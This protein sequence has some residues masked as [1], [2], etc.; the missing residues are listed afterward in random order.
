MASQAP[1]N[2]PA[3]YNELEPLNSQAHGT[4]KLRMIDR[5]PGIGKLHAVPLTVDEFSL[6]Q[7]DFY[8]SHSVARRQ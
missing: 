7:R 5:I 3:L 6:A 8:A 4:K 2:F 1:A